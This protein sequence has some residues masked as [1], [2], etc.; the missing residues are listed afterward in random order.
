LFVKTLEFN[1]KTNSNIIIR[2]LASDHGGIIEI[3][4]LH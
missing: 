2:Y 3:A 4:Q 1:C